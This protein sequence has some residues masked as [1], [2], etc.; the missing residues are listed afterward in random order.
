[1]AGVAAGVIAYFQDK[2]AWF[3]VVLAVA[4]GIFVACVV[5]L[6]FKSLRLENAEGRHLKH[7]PKLVYD[8]HRRRCVVREQFVSKINWD[9]VDT[10]EVI[11]RTFELLTE[12]GQ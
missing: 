3:I 9:K 7:L 1:V 4:V 2:P 8:M 11:L 6:F 10:S 5:S 12:E